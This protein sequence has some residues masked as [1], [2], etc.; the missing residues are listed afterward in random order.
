M[1]REVLLPSRIYTVVLWFVEYVIKVDATVELEEQ[2]TMK[3]GRLGPGDHSYQQA[4][5]TGDGGS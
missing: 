5:L 4:G 1:K 2:E 3:W